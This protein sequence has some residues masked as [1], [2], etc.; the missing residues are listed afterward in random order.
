M[1]VCVCVYVRICLGFLKRYLKVRL[2]VDNRLDV[3]VNAK[4]GL[5]SLEE[6][7]V[8]VDFVV[9]DIVVV[10]VCLCFCFSS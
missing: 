8:F 9:S 4:G 1:C 5:N 10:G 6:V 2:G 3:A 7:F